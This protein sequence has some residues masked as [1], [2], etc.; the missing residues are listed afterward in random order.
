M[1]NLPLHIKKYLNDRGISDETIQKVDLNW[2]NNKI[3]IPVKDK[4]GKLLFNKYRRSPDAD[5]NDSKY[6][7][8]PGSTASLYN[9]NNVKG[10][11]KTVF[12]TEGELDA[13]CLM[14]HGFDAVSTT[15]GSGTFKQEWA[16]ELSRFENIYICYDRDIA[17]I[18]GMIRVNRLMP[19]AKVIILPEV[20]GKDVTEYV[21]AKGLAEFC[22]LE[23]SAKSWVIPEP[24]NT[25][26]K[27]SQVKAYNALADEALAYRRQHP[28]L[29]N[30]VDLITDVILTYKSEVKPIK[31]NKVW[32]NN[33]T[34]SEIAAAKAVP[35]TEFLKFNKQGFAHCVWHQEKTPSLKYYPIDNRVYCFGGCSRGGDTLDVVQ[36]IHSCTM[37]EAIKIILKK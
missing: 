20:N 25:V 3:V 28:E 32:V 29:H 8:D 33:G 21:I 31:R 5:A 14:S 6:T 10:S 4:D 30:P 37:Q 35:L 24:D 26:S 19:K 7:Y 18:K 27:A 15:G 16:D 2:S 34:G 23:S 11:S 36:Q 13:L 9:L 12:V 22:K 1:T 17:G